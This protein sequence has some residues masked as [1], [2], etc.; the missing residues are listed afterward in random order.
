MRALLGARIARAGLD[1]TPTTWEDHPMHSNA[2]LLGGLIVMLLI[3]AIGIGGPSMIY[4]F[5]NRKD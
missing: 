3:I 2:T 4:L 5:I 1:T